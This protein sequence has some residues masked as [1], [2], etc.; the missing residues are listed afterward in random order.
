MQSNAI[1]AIPVS[2]MQNV[3]LELTAKIYSVDWQD[4]RLESR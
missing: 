1:G 4:Q 3:L 2:P